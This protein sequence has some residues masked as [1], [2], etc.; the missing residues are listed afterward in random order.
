MTCSWCSHAIPPQDGNAPLVAHSHGICKA[1][2]RRELAEGIKD[3]RKLKRD[4]DTYADE[5][6]SERPGPVERTLS[7]LY[8]VPLT[9]SQVF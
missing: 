3:A 2:A 7:T 9:L 5:Q 1:C 6:A 8:G 4:L